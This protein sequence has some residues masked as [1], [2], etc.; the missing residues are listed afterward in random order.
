MMLLKYSVE[1][2]FWLRFEL[3][4]LSFTNFCYFEELK[5]TRWTRHRELIL[6]PF[7]FW[8]LFGAVT[9]IHY[10]DNNYRL[11]KKED[12]QCMVIEKETNQC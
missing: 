8:G 1:L 6:K 10:G 2:F 3:I 11:S 4:F 9:V 5:L 7:N 12:C